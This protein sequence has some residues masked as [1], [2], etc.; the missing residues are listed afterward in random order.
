MKV[1]VV[2]G[3]TRENIDSVRFITNFS[4]GATGK[5]ISECLDQNNFQVFHLYGESSKRNL[6]IAGESF[7]S[8]KSLNEK[9]KEKLREKFDVIIMNAAI[10]DYSVDF[11]EINQRSYEPFEIDKIDSSSEV[12]INLKRNFKLLNRLREYSLNKNIKIIAFKLTSNANSIEISTKVNKVFES[13]VDLVIHN[14]LSEISLE[15]H[16]GKVFDSPQSLIGEFE[17]KDELCDEILKF[18]RGS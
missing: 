9:L 3:A 14:D 1:L 8:F 15:K 11:L 2:S 10:S 16:I 6:N 17:T 13:D 18:V 5:K 4:T 12:K 7:C